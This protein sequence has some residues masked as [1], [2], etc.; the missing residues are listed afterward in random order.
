MQGVIVALINSQ[1]YLE[2]QGIK[3]NTQDSMFKGFTNYK[4][5]YQ[6]KWFLFDLDILR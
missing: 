3:T 1:W 4:D 6:E 2:K 5:P